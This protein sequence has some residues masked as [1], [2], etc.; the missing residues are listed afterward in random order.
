M[1]DS[2]GFS[3]NIPHGQLGAQGF[4]QESLF[5]MALYTVHVHDGLSAAVGHS[6]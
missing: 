2:R 3:L 5:Q 4:Q 6:R 1:C